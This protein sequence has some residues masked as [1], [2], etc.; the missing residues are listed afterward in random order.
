VRVV[1]EYRGH[2][3]VTDGMRFGVEWPTGVDLGYESTKDARAEVASELGSSTYRQNRDE[4][5]WLVVPHDSPLACAC[6]GGRRRRESRRR[7]SQPDCTPEPD[8]VLVFRR[9]AGRLVR[10]GA[11]R[12]IAVRR[13]DVCEEPSGDLEHRRMLERVVGSL[14][15]SEPSADL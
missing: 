8:A 6:C 3:I 1:E 13:Y 11:V 7:R 9:D 2:R 14:R 15:D 5:L 10:V 4:S 12:A